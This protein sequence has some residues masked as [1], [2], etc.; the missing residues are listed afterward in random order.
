[1]VKWVFLVLIVFISRAKK[2]FGVTVYTCDILHKI[3]FHNELPKFPQKSPHSLKPK[4]SPNLLFRGKSLELATP[5]LGL[6]KGTL[7]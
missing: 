2:D 5:A 7:L 6:K 3:F 4:R 1:M